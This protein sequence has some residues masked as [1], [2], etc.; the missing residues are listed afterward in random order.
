M[1]TQ[2][3]FSCLLMLAVKKKHKNL[4]NMLISRDSKLP[5]VNHFGHGPDCGREGQHVPAV[6]KGN[7]WQWHCKG[8][9]HLQRALQMNQPSLWSD[10]LL[11]LS[12]WQRKQSCT[13]C[14]TAKMRLWGLKTLQRQD[15]TK[16]STPTYSAARL[17]FFKHTFDLLDTSLCHQRS[18]PH[19]GKPSTLS[20]KPMSN[21]IIFSC[22]T[23][24]ALLKA[25][26]SVV[27]TN[28]TW[29]KCTFQKCC[30]KLKR[31]QIWGSSPKKTPNPNTTQA[32]QNREQG[33]DTTVGAV[34]Q[35][36]KTKKLRNMLHSIFKTY[37]HQEISR[38]LETQSKESK[39]F[40]DLRYPFNW[41]R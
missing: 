21:L 10:S 7:G 4:S 37:E 17:P 8:T 31:I 12:Q 29:Q 16:Y 2:S 25:L 30:M 9:G 39:V 14:T 1:V 13:P 27:S 26:R 11:A 19:L 24:R 35:L 23:S 34:L 33:V 22:K 40:S 18:F 38:C 3:C 28:F 36:D 15:E 20:A 41:L 6:R 32:C 5:P